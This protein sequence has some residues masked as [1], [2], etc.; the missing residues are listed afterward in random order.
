MTTELAPID[1]TVQE[2]MHLSEVPKEAM[3][4]EMDR[5]YLG[6][7]VKQNPTLAKEDFVNFITKC[8]LT[9]ADPRMNQ[10]YLIVHNAWNSQK[11]VSEPKGTT[12]F[13]YQFFL[14]LAQQ[15]GQLEGMNVELIREPYLDLQSGKERASVTAKCH[16]K[17]LG[18]GEI[19]YQA[20]F[21]EFAK[22]DKDGNLSG[23]WKNSPY[24]MLEK[25]AVANALRWAFPETLGNMYIADEMEKATGKPVA[26][27]IEPI[28][29]IVKPQPEPKI[30]TPERD[31]EDMRD[32][33][34]EFLATRSDEWFER[35]GRDRVKMVAMVE[36]EQDLAVMKAIMAK[37]L[38]YD[39]QASTQGDKQ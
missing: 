2:L 12:V 38:Q 14:R 34:R 23:N 8:Q 35:I 36:T 33:I 13:S 29:A 3:V 37:T 1:T 17:R 10:I 22:T 4:R 19:V 24:L 28:K 26:I 11:R 18:Q 15:T 5:N 32:E 9:G 20:R 25:C 21:W 31:I 30:E 39:K 27:D 6:M 16:I 7:L